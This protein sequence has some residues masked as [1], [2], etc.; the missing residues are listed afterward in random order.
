MERVAALRIP[1]MFIFPEEA[2]EGGFAAYGPRDS[3]LFVEVMLQQIV[4][5]FRGKKVADI[6]VEQATR[7]ELVST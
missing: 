5:L 6:P 7:F 3:H 2:E 1:A 4:K